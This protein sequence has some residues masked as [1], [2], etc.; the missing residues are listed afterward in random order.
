M[1][2]T[3][4]DSHQCNKFR[5]SILL[6]LHEKALEKAK[7]HPN[8]VRIGSLGFSQ[9][10]GVALTVLKVTALAEP[11]FKG[12][13]NLVGSPISNKCKVNHGLR[14]LFISTPIEILS[15]CT[16]P[17]ELVLLIPYITVAM[18][19]NP[20]WHCQRYINTF[21]KTSDNPFEKQMEDAFVKSSTEL[22]QKGFVA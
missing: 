2:I 1:S 9:T 6:S 21:Q 11:I 17:I 5:S 18:M 14:Q 20:N 16:V 8:T 22:F 19:V 4:S 7:K 3:L 15:V 10:Y 13:I 12:L